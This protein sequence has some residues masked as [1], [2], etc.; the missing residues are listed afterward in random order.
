MNSPAF[1]SYSESYGGMHLMSDE[2]ES[3][4][5]LGYSFP[6]NYSVWAYP[7][8]FSSELMAHVY[9]CEE[10]LYAIEIHTTTYA[11]LRALPLFA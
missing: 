10:K 8:G 5:K 4:E 9:V 11:K 6:S 7:G 1:S 2:L 3:K